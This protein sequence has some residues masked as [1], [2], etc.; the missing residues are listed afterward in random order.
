MF[1]KN[2]ARDYIENMLIAPFFSKQAKYIG[3]ELEYPILFIDNSLSSK[4]LGIEFLTFLINTGDFEEEK[5]TC[6]PEIMRV[7]NR[8]AD[9]ISYDYTYATIEFSMA[10]AV[11]IHEIAERF[12]GY[13]DT[14][15]NY[16]KSKGCIITGMGSNPFMPEKLEYTIS[17][18][19]N[20]LR[21]YIRLYTPQKDPQYYLANMQS[22]QTH[23]EVPGRTLPEKFNTMCMM[24]FVKAL[25]L[26]NSLP[27]PS[28]LP[29]GINYEEGT[30]CARDLNWEG[31]GFPN[32]G[33]CNQR[34]DDVEQIIDYFTDKDICFKVDGLEYECFKPVSLH[35][36][37]NEQMHP[38]SDINGFFNVERVTINRYNVIEMRGDCIQPLNSTFCATAFNI[39]I[40]QNS[41]KALQ[42]CDL[43]IATNRLTGLDIKKLRKLAITNRFTELVSPKTLSSF[44]TEMI[45]IAK[46]GLM[47]RGYGEEIYLQPLY[48]RATKLKSPAEYQLQ[49]ISEGQDIIEIA[50]LYADRTNGKA[51]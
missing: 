1:T 39:G 25:L 35:E 31:S 23:I 38:E 51:T 11:T 22:V 20:T 6:S 46:E 27:Q 14:A 32:T 42:I 17:N 3:V 21:N 44:L 4:Q 12:Y 28:N 8:Y 50:K 43:F 36:Y 47:S 33:I 9:S 40:C 19:T 24:D 45:N 30:L 7:N 13:F 18:Y 29:P 37:F 26:S 41:S 2:G 5:G 15:S 34:F 48:E 16:Y 10:K 49:L